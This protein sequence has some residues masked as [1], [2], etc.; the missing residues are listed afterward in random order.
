MGAPAG[1]TEIHRTRGLLSCRLRI[2]RGVP[3]S[4]TSGPL[5]IDLARRILGSRRDR[6][7]N[8]ARWAGRSNPPRGRG[9]LTFLKCSFPQGWNCLASKSM[10]GCA[11][12]EDPTSGSPYDALRISGRVVYPIRPSPDANRTSS[13]C[14]SSSLTSQGFYS[15]HALRPHGDHERSIAR[16]RISTCPSASP[17]PRARWRRRRYTHVSDQEMYEAIRAVGT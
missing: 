2:M 16:G 14:G 10:P 3:G 15:F 6:R 9:Y 4:T 1:C 5:T 17:A 12:M 7:C 13:T 8:R 11:S